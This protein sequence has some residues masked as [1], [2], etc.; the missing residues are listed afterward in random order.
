MKTK[1]LKFIVFCLILGSFSSCDKKNECKKIVITSI[2]NDPSATLTNTNWKLVGF[3]DV[4]K[5]CLKKAKP[6]GERCYTLAFKGSLSEDTLFIYGRDTNINCH[7][8]FFGY[9]STNE[10]V[11][12][13]SIDHKICDF[14]IC[15]GGIRTL[16]GETA[17]GERYNDALFAVQSFS[18]YENE[19]RLYYNNKNN[20]LLF[21]KQ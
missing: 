20:Y 21:K 5:E 17:D 18:L 10:I 14:R 11:C 1:N 16:A 19:L 9:T 2:V 8:I 7:T 13:C 12:T 6:E 15:S 3:V 4:E